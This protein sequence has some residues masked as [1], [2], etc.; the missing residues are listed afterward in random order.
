MEQWF[1]NAYTADIICYHTYYMYVH[2]IF[3]DM[4]HQKQSNYYTIIECKK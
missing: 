1:C 4:F 2:N 3:I